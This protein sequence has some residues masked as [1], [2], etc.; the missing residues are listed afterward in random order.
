MEIPQELEAIGDKTYPLPCFN[1]TR[2]WLTWW[3]SAVGRGSP[4]Q[5]AECVDCTS[6]Y[7]D[8]MM[9]EVR[10]SHPGVVFLK[11]EEGA[12]FGAR[13]GTVVYLYRPTGNQP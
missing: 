10:C 8:K 9:A 3:S 13:P 2:E 6:A 4:G 7:K 11:N 5:S 1:S 12:E